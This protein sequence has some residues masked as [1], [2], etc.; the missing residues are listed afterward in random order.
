MLRIGAHGRMVV[1]NGGIHHEAASQARLIGQSC[2]SCQREITARTVSSNNDL[3]IVGGE[4][5]EVIDDPP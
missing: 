3:T 1:L 5:I 4:R 2:S